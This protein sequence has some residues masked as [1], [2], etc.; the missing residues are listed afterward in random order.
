[1][2]FSNLDLKRN[3]KGKRIN[4]KNG[5]LSPQ[6][7]L[8]WPSPSSPLCA[9]QAQVAQPTDQ[10]GLLVSLTEKRAKGRKRFAPRGIELGSPR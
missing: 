1:M 4:R 8:D 5:G 7:L 9:D 2:N 10:W 3:W 6:D